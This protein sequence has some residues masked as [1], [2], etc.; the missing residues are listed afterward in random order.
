MPQLRNQ[1][2]RFCHLG[3]IVSERSLAC[4]GDALTAGMLES[5]LDALPLDVTFVA[6]DDT[7]R[8]YNRNAD[9]VFERTP[10]LIG[11]RVQTC[12]GMSKLAATQ[13]TRILRT[14]RD[15]TCSEITRFTETNGETLYVRYAAVRN[16][17]GMFLGVLQTTQRLPES[18]SL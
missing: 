3:E 4:E 7:I 16:R 15:T 13:V 5:L 2:P 6:A 9:K 12:H 18:V 14:L 11:K 1:L 8:Y 17:D 10:D